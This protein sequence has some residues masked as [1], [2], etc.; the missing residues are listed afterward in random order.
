MDFLL[1]AIVALITPY[2]IVVLLILT[3]YKKIQ[4]TRKNYSYRPTVTIF[5][6]TYNEEEFIEKKLKNLLSQS[7]PVKEILVYDCST[8]RTPSI[9]EEY[10]KTIP[11]IKLTK[12]RER[13]GMARTLNQAIEQSS[14][15]IFV[16]T[17]VDSITI[18]KN[19]LTELVANFADEKIGAVTGTRIN[20]NGIERYYNKFMNLIQIAESNIDSVLIGHSSSLLAFRRKLVEE[21][22]LFSM[23]EDTEEMVI[24]RRKGYRTIVDPSVISEEV[25]PEEFKKRR[26]QKDRRAEGIIRVLLKNKQMIFHPK[27]GK[28]GLVVLPLELFILIISPF[29]LP[30]LFSLL[31]IET[32]LYYPTWGFIFLAGLIVPAFIKKTPLNAIIDVQISGIV[33]TLRSIL[34]RDNPLWDKVR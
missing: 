5:L 27:Y 30:V 20:R 23:A 19:G 13:V 9:I 25:I 21:V 4:K 3:H 6:P 28:Y 10:Q 31:I 17:D 14:G 18:S 22:S 32:Y 2:S 16:K 29:L 8:D 24:I 1:F 11:A 7:Y 34:K 15:E 12:Q 33:A 26:E